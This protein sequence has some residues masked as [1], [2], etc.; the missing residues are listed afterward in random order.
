MQTGCAQSGASGCISCRPGRLTKVAGEGLPWPTLH[1]GRWHLHSGWPGRAAQ[2]SRPLRS[3]QLTPDKP[4]CSDSL[5]CLL[6]KTG[7]YWPLN[8]PLG[9]RPP[10]RGR[11]LNARPSWAGCSSQSGLWPAGAGAQAG[12][13][14][15]EAGASGRAAGPSW[16]AEISVCQEADSHL[17]LADSAQGSLT[18]NGRHSCFPLEGWPG[19]GGLCGEGKGAGLGIPC[20]ALP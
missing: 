12:A 1:A 4:A 9:H 18:G 19:T 15:R 16:T 5:L 3:P 11:C 13:R 8:G 7:I 20:L 14:P 10:W 6:G 2:V 17:F